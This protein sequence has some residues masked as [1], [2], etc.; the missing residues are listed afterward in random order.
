MCWRC[1]TSVTARSPWGKD[2]VLDYEVMSDQEWE[3]EP[4]GESLSVC[5][6]TIICC[7]ANATAAPAFPDSNISNFKI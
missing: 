7:L 2:E 1:S 3:E 6:L 5:P 4:E